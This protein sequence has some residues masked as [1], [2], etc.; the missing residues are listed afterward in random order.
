MKV[1]PSITTVFWP[2]VVL[3]GTPAAANA[4]DASGTSTNA[5]N[6][7]AAARGAAIIRGRHIPVVE[8]ATGGSPIPVVGDG[9]AV[10]A[11][12]LVAAA[13][14]DGSPIPVVGDGDA[15]IAS[16]QYV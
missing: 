12:R 14:L 7:A 9:D 8:N 4:T 2:F 13:C 11:A 6:N 5:G 1:L 15:V 16:E 10:I 3:R